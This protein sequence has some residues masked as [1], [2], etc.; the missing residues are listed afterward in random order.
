MLDV[1]LNFRDPRH[2]DDFDDDERDLISEESPDLSLHED[3]K[4]E[5]FDEEPEIDLSPGPVEGSIDPVRTYLRDMGK[6]PL[7]KREGEVRVAQRIE[8]GQMLVLRALS[9]GGRTFVTDQQKLPPGEPI[10]A[11][12]VNR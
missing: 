7:L 9:A 4:W 8:R 5:E 3:D 10:Q 12:E 2:A 6:V 11:A 1:K